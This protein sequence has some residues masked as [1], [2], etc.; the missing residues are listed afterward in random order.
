[1]GPFKLT[2]QQANNFIAKVEKTPSGCW[3]WSGCRN[4]QGYGQ[5][6]LGR[7]CAH[8]THRIVFF[9]IKPETSRSL[10]VCHSC[11]NPSC[12]NPDH[13]FAGTRVDNMRDMALKA[14]GNTAKLTAD[15]ISEIRRSAGKSSQLAK[16]FGVT[17]GQINKIKRGE[18]HKNLTVRHR[19]ERTTPRPNENPHD[20]CV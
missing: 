7:G 12:V 10:H 9:S 2:E 8:G 1:M 4:R 5:V 19:G 3:E 16:Q 20:L 18:H 11:D 6:R 15:D 14:R 17:A 13:L